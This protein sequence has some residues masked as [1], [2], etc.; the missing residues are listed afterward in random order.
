MVL[1]EATASIDKETAEEVM[2]VLRKELKRSTV[3]SIAHRAEAVYGVQNCLVLSKG[4]VVRQ[5]DPAE[6]ARGGGGGSASASG[7]RSATPAVVE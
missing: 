7:S 6:F 4:R 3:V 2:K 5:G 1:D